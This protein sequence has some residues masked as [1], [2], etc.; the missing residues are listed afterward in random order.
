MTGVKSPQYWYV[1]DDS[2][3]SESAGSSCGY[4]GYRRVNIQ[5]TCWMSSALCEELKDARP[6]VLLKD[7]AVEKGTLRLSSSCL[8]KICIIFGMYRNKF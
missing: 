8:V 6:T 3:Q 2:L 1:V 7:V 5:P 4:H